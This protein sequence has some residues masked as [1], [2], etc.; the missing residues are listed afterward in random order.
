MERQASI[1]NYVTD[2]GDPSQTPNVRPPPQIQNIATST[3]REP[4]MEK[5]VNCPNQ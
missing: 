3:R 5:N 1:R 2:E 4:L